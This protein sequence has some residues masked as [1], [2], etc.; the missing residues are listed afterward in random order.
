MKF[1]NKTSI[2]VG[3]SYHKGTGKWRAKIN[4]DNYCLSLGLFDSEKLAHE[5]YCMALKE[6]HNET[7]K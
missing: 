1:F 3:V 7:L 2:F 6:L 5:A 4:K